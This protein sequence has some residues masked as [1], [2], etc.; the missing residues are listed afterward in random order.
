MDYHQ[1]IIRDSKIRGG[2]PVIKGTRVT[3]RTI[4]ARLPEGTHIEGFLRIF[5]L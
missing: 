5:P 3:I 1:Y 2:Q 4:L